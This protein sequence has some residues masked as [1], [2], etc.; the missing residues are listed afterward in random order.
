[1]PALAERPVPPGATA[2]PRRRRS[3]R[4]EPTIEKAATS[5]AKTPRTEGRPAAAKAKPRKESAKPAPR[6]GS[7]KRHP[8]RGA[9]LASA[10]PGLSGIGR[11]LEAVGERI[12]RISRTVE[13]R[14]AAALSTVFIAIAA[15][16]AADGPAAVERAVDRMTRAS[17]VAL[18]FS[19]DRVTAEGMVSTSPAAL[20]MAL[21]VAERQS[22]LHYDLGEARGR[23]EALDWVARAEVYRFLPHTLHVVIEERRPVAIWTRDSMRFLID[24]EGALI[25]SVPAGVDPRSDGDLVAVSG[26]GAASAV[27]DLIDILKERPE[28]SDRLVL[29]ERVGERRWTLMLRGDVELQLP[30]DRPGAALDYVLSKESEVAILSGHVRKVDMRMLWTEKSIAVVFSDNAMKRF[31]IRENPPANGRGAKSKTDH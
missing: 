10:G 20:D 15:F 13:A 11:A 22:L 28:V 23:I 12:A 8:A 18:G 29:A 17:A 4:V 7:R 9:K 5:S 1:M 25:T 19:I 16:V 14:R 24:R 30:E 2:K 6:S 26:P 31:S 21:R 27:A 3:E